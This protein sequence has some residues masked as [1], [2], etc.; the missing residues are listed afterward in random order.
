M[1]C[2]ASNRPYFYVAPTTDEY[3]E[4]IDFPLPIGETLV[5]IPFSRAKASSA[6]RHHGLIIY[7]GVDASV[8]VLSFIVTHMDALGITIV[9]SAPPETGNYR[10]RGVVSVLP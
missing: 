8:S 6:L 7:N 4:Y 3:Q 5:Q 9:L 1:S 2:Y 10:I